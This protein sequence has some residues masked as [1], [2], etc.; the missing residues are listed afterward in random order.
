MPYSKK[1]LALYRLSKA[2]D[3]YETALYNQKIGKYRQANNRSYYSI[4]HAM[5]AVLALKN[6]DFAKHSSV[7][8]NFNQHFVK[9]GYFNKKL[10][11]YVSQASAIRNKSDYDDFYIV[12]I[13]E[14]KQLL[15]IAKEFYDEVEKYI[16]DCKEDI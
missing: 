6:M 1:E 14:T 5:R 2:L 12:S 10:S 3:D 4:F 8:A 9:S 11:K 16:A 13:E 7:I 15:S